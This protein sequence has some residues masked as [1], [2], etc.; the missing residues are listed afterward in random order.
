MA[1]AA[2]FMMEVALAMFDIAIDM[3]LVH[4]I[5]MTPDDIL[6]VFI[7]FA[8]G[9]YHTPPPAEYDYVVF[10]TNV[11]KPVYLSCDSTTRDGIRAR[12][13]L[14][15]QSYYCDS[16]FTLTAMADAMGTEMGK[17]MSQ[18][19][20][21]VPHT[22]MST[23]LA[24][25][26]V[27]EPEMSGALATCI[28]TILLRGT[29]S[30]TV[31]LQ[32]MDEGSSRRAYVVHM[33]L[34]HS[35][36][37]DWV[38]TRADGLP[39]DDNPV[40]IIPKHMIRPYPHKNWSPTPTR[41]CIEGLVDPKILKTFADRMHAQ[42]T[43]GGE[44]V[45]VALVMRFVDCAVH[46]FWPTI[47]RKTMYVSFSTS[48]TAPRIL[49]NDTTRQRK[50][51]RTPALTFFIEAAVYACWLTDAR[52]QRDFESFFSS[53]SRAGRRPPS[54]QHLLSHVVR[55][56]NKEHEPIQETTTYSN[57]TKRRHFYELGSRRT[58]LHNLH[59]DATDL[60]LEENPAYN[61][62]VEEPCGAYNPEPIGFE[63]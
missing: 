13:A 28:I 56:I 8:A 15:L 57:S 51:P 41:L 50:R 4:T 18:E 35:F 49:Y 54:L 19:M 37:P 12:L 63:V 17:A 53:K 2:S 3:K 11:T 44:S 45:E 36:E 47:L 48:K 62:S 24:L 23:K 5:D 31:T 38:L 52:F 20:S 6:T 39:L 10:S 7:R 46:R 43:P 60:L 16:R 30:E 32:K 42:G 27:F 40:P 61:G 1:H 26:H 33:H 9:A 22:N 21:A 34:P 55:A 25:D 14:H 59:F 58:N 29:N